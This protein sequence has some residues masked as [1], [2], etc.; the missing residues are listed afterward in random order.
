VSRDPE[1]QAKA[2]VADHETAIEIEPDLVF[3]WET[4]LTSPP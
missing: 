1:Q 2:T 3:T 4:A